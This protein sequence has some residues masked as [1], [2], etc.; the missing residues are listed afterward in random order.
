MQSTILTT[1]FNVVKRLAVFTFDNEYYY[2]EPTESIVLS[3]KLKDKIT[4]KP[5]KNCTI[6]YD[7]DS[8]TYSTTS[9]V[10]GSA[11][12][13]IEIPDA[14]KIHCLDV[15]IDDMVDIVENEEGEPYVDEY[16]EPLQDFDD[17]GNIIEI[18]D[19]EEIDVQFE[20]DSLEPTNNESSDTFI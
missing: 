10:S 18:E 6:K 11:F 13:N 1:D 8:E 4:N 2:G 3:G 7:F 16:E 12:F 19:D 5:V 9:N 14:N 15:T 20:A 17:D